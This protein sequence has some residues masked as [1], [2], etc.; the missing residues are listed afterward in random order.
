MEAVKVV[1][2]AL[3]QYQKQLE[4]SRKYYDKKAGPKELRRP[5]GRVKG[6]KNRP[7]LAEENVAEDQTKTV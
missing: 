3:K 5:R 1:E 7:K 2:Q 4:A 6:S